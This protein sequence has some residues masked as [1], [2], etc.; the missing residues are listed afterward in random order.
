M[1]NRASLP[2]HSFATSF[3]ATSWKINPFVLGGFRRGNRLRI[4]YIS[5]IHVI[6]EYVVKA[7]N[8]NDRNWILI[9]FRC[10]TLFTVVRESIRVLVIQNFYKYIQ[11]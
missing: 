7:K 6:F 11:I 5:F 3:N 9:R 1:R 4:K 2:R 8:L 10:E